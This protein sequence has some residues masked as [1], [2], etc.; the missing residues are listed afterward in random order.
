MS[1]KGIPAATAQAMFKAAL[2]RF[3]KLRIRAAPGPAT[4]P[5]KAPLKRFPQRVLQVSPPPRRGGAAA[6]R[7]S[8]WAC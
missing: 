1:P 7:C 5:L 6:A 3:F 4:N 8:P 2:K